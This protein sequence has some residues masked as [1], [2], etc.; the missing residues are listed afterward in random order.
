MGD[1]KDEWEISFQ[2]MEA[3]ERQVRREVGRTVK[4]VAK[5]LFDQGVELT[6]D[7]FNSMATLEY[8]DPTSRTTATR[9]R[10]RRRRRNYR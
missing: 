8:A 2:E 7:L 9:R 5:E 6:A 3:I 10:F 4:S 1:L